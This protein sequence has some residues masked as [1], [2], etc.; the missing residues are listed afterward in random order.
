MRKRG[1]QLE[2]NSS[3]DP[4]FR[5]GRLGRPHGLDG[6]L[7]LY[8]DEADL[9]YFQPGSTVFVADRPLRV[10]AI[11]RADRGHHVAFEGVTDR[12][13]AE[14]IRSLDVHVPERRALGEEE[15]WPEDLVGLEVRP[16]GGSVVD[17][18][19]GPAQDRLVIERDGQRF[20]VPFVEALV[21]VV[22]VEGGFVE[23]VEIEGL[24]EQTGR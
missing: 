2:S 22:D 20:E 9:E 1:S 23:V 17:V 13:A 15:Y 21:P 24:S 16:G 19:H 10:R 4:G 3:T 12:E 8:V 18:S 11:R 5:V 14:A 7:G 6:F